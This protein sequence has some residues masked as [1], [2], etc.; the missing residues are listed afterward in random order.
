MKGFK[1]RQRKSLMNSSTLLVS[2]DGIQVG[3]FQEVVQARG[4]D[5]VIV[6]ANNTSFS[7]TAI[8]DTV[9]AISTAK[10]YVPSVEL[11][12]NTGTKLTLS[13][14]ALRS[15]N[16][17]GIGFL[18]DPG[19]ETVTGGLLAQ[20]SLLTD[21]GAAAIFDTFDARTSSYSEL[22]LEDGLS[23]NKKTFGKGLE[24]SL[25]DEGIPDFVSDLSASITL[26]LTAEEFGTIVSLNQNILSNVTE[27]VA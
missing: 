5:R 9:S 11:A 10:N 7:D 1:S 4:I 2:L 19:F 8:N 22:T 25:S 3:S 27:K 21:A 15:L 12:L 17:T 24:V 20:T 13:T 16:S 18:N 6:V 23:I 26:N 14:D